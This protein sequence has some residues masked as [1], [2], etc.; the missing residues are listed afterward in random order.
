MFL[1]GA[2]FLRFAQLKDGEREALRPLVVHDLVELVGLITGRTNPKGRFDVFC[3]AV[4]DVHGLANIHLASGLLLNHV[5]AGFLVGVQFLAK[6]LERSLVVFSPNQL[7]YG[8]A[9]REPWAKLSQE[10]NVRLFGRSQIQRVL[11]VVILFLGCC[12]HFLLMRRERPTRL[13]D[14]GVQVAKY[15]LQPGQLMA[16]L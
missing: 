12:L 3:P 1:A 9:V 14:F 10:C 16:V 4:A 5:D 8:V 11:A 15:L 7:V 13:R 2:Q 6:I